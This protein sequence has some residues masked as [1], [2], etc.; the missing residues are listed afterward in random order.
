MRMPG[1]ASTVSYS[2]DSV[3]INYIPPLVE[4]DGSTASTATLCPSPV[5][6]LPNTSINVDFPAPGGPERPVSYTCEFLGS[7]ALFRC[8]MGLKSN[9]VHCT[10]HDNFKTN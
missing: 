9:T 6:C 2:F 10:T 8:L 4:E 5:I 7:R 1:Y 3:T